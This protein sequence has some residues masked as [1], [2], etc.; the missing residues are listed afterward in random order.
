M[1]RL[2]YHDILY[3]DAQLGPYPDHLLK[4]VPEP[5]NRVPGPVERRS[6]RESVFNKSLMGDFGEDLQREF[7]RLG[8]RYPIVAAM[9][10]L[11]LHI[12]AYGEARP[13]VAARRAPLP[14]DPRVMSRHLKALGYYLGADQVRIGPLAPS[15]VYYE[16]AARRP[17]EAPYRY[18]IVFAAR[19]HSRSL[20]ASNGWD[21]IVSPLSHQVYQKLALQTEVTANYLRRLGV[22]AVPSYMRRYLTL[23]PQIVLDAGMGEISRMGIVLNPFYGCNCK[24]S[25]VLTSL[26]LEVDG[27]VDF[28]LQEYCDKCTVCA[29]QCPSHAIPRGEQTLHNGYYTWRLNAR[30]CSDF[31]ILNKEGTVCGRCTKVCP[32]NRPDM[33][34]RD[35]AEWDGNLEWLHATVDEQHKRNLANGFVDPR[36]YTDKWWFRLEDR[37]GE[38][39]TPEGKNA[40]K[41]CRDHPIQE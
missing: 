30:A 35:F 32:W 21:D 22:D 28:G 34:P 18:A 16:D 40:E 41:I 37:E 6:E 20:S 27:Y 15:A 12:A 11:Q 31:G 7:K 23:M 3:N 24:Y 26:E 19:K 1:E 10:D 29:E 25:A 9:Q 14:D 39:V 2:R 36:E 38:I 13:P 5:T 8:T 4:R 17:I 33:E